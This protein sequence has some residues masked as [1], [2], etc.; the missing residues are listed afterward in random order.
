MSKQ[1]KDM[2]KIIKTPGNILKIYLLVY[3]IIIFKTIQIPA[4]CKSFLSQNGLHL[5]K[6][7]SFILHKTDIAQVIPSVMYAGKNAGWFSNLE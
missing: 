1:Y 5:G 3:N 4:H 2:K 7:P 6:S